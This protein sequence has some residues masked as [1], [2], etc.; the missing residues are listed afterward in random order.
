MSVTEAQG[1]SASGVA[2]GLKSSGAKDVSLV[3]N[4]G[5]KVISAAVFTQNRFAAAPVLWSRQILRGGDGRVVVLNSGGANACTGPQGFA[6]THRTAELVASSLSAQGFDDFG[7]GEVYVCSTGLIG[8]PLN[9]MALEAGVSSAIAELSPN[10]GIMAA[11]AIM[12]TDTK[13]KVSAVVEHGYTIGGMAKGAGMLAPG[14]ATML[15]VIT[16]DAD[17]DPQ[18][19]QQALSAATAQ[20]FD[21]LDSDGCMST[22][23]TVILLANAASG[24]T[25]NQENFQ[26]SLTKVCEELAQLLMADAEGATKE[27]HIEIIGAR[28]ESDAVTVGRAVSRSNLFKC[29]MFGEDPNWGRILSAVGTTDAFFEPDQVDVTINGVKICVGGGVGE[30][31]SL[32]DLSQRHIDVIVDLHSGEDRALIRT[33]DLSVGYVLENSEYST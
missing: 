33:N 18:F 3:V 8:E 1:F 5:P 6:D 13:Y 32:V 25:P 9:M 15:S 26:T 24:V 28:T 14:M 22:N 23:D 16:T 19:L 12:T 4:T 17:V 21:R 11:Q 7:A 10:G 31:R 29:A 30:D 2:A 20:T 27:I